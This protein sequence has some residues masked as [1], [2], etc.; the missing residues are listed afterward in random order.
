MGCVF[1]SKCQVTAG[2]GFNCRWLQPTD[3]T[4]MKTGWAS[5]SFHTMRLKPGKLFKP[6]N[7]LDKSNGNTRKAM[8]RELHTIGKQI[9]PVS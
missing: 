4:K 5:A 2:V 8:D 3:N 9:I 6:F 7:P 1:L